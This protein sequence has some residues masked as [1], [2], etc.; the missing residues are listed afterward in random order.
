[1]ARGIDM[2]SEVSQTA[3]MMSRQ[4]PVFIRGRNG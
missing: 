3:A 2:E 4:T 1:M